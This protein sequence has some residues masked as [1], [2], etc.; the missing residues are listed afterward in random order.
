MGVD[1]SKFDPKTLELLKK[2]E[3]NRPEVK[4]LEELKKVSEQLAS[5]TTYL[6]K[7]TKNGEQF[8]GDIAE[9]LFDVK[10][11]LIAFSEKEDPEYPDLAK[12]VTEALGAFKKELTAALSKIDV[13]PQVNVT[14]PDVKVPEPKV[15]VKVDLKGVEKAFDKAVKSIPKGE[16]PESYEKV[17]REMLDKLDEIDTGV[18]MKPQA[19][20]VVKVT[21]QDGTPVGSTYTPVPIKKV[22]V[23]KSTTTD[24]IY[25]GKAEPGSG[26][27]DP[28]WA[29]AKVDKTVTDNVAITYGNGG[30]PNNRWSERATV[31]TYS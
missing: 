11:A 14:S 28:V 1:Y 3:S 19:P 2:V 9:V 31:V 15:E 18:R 20:G 23:D 22:L 5:L 13:K 21:N 12:P 7:Q 10:E 4:Q 26:T 25:I 17:F 8:N 29:I 16:K 6:Q 30:S 24:V 27:T